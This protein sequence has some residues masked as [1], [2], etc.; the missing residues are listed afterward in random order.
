MSIAELPQ[1]SV[2]QADTDYL[3]FKTEKRKTEY[4]LLTKLRGGHLNP[5][6]A[7]LSVS[8]QMRNRPV[9]FRPRVH[10]VKRSDHDAESSGAAVNPV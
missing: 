9:R 10:L 8:I 4:V 2:N 7:A 1:V 5:N 6:A 3:D